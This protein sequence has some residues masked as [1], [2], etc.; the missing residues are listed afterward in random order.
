ML[1][2]AT[3]AMDFQLV[4]LHGETLGVGKR[5]DTLLQLGVVVRGDG[6]AAPRTADVVMVA[7]E[8]IAQLQLVLPAD[9]QPLDDTQFLEQGDGAVDTGPVGR[10]LAGSYQ[11][12]HGLRLGV[13][14]CQKDRLARLRHAMALVAE[15]RPELLSG[16]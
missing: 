10:I 16:I 13:L 8:G 6:G 7:A 5:F 1:T 4:A 12:A 14:Q 2:L 9:L 3:Q 11:L 15:Y